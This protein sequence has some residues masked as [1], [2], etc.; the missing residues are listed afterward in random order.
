MSL[1]VPEI[2]VNY[3]TVDEASGA[4]IIQRELSARFGAARVFMDHRSIAPGQEFAAEL[5]NGVRRSTVLLA[6]IGVHWL[7][8]HGRTEL[9]EESDWIR[10]ELL[11]ARDSDVLVVPVLLGRPRLS[12]TELPADLAWLA[13]LQHISLDFRE[14]DHGLRVLGDKLVQLGPG[15][16][17]VDQHDTTTPQ[18]NAGVT[19]S[20]G[21]ATGP[22]HMGQ[23]NQY[24]H[25]TR[26]E[27]R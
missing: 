12:R 9:A 5:I 4:S 26:G 17:S 15:L 11:L 2:F 7:D 23:G 6:V 10:R 20:I 16:A 19:N 8:E 13:D 27:H 1:P 14:I 21:T 22:V 24:N 3:R 25:F 18:Q